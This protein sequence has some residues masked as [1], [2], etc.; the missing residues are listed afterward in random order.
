MNPYY[1][2]NQQTRMLNSSISG[3]SMMNQGGNLIDSRQINHQGLNDGN[4]PIS[5]ILMED[6]P[7]FVGPSFVDDVL[8]SKQNFDQM[9]HANGSLMNLLGQNQTSAFS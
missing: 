2:Q 3:M 9:Q 8:L 5:R 1:F 7:N 4:D 6:Q